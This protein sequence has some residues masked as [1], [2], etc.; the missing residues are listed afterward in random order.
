MTRTSPSYI[1]QVTATRVIYDSP[2][3]PTV[4][5]QPQPEAEGP[6]QGAREQRP[7][8]AKGS[9]CDLLG[10]GGAVVWV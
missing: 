4:A 6:K 7:G 5:L 3:P 9:G 8:H 1:S 2:P 10:G